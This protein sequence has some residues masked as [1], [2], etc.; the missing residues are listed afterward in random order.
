MRSMRRLAIPVLAAL[1]MLASGAGSATAAMPRIIGGQPAN[2]ESW[3]FA[4]ALTTDYGSQFCAGSLVQPQW[5]LT[6]GHC[7]IYAPSAVRVVVGQVDLRERSGGI[8]VERMIRS[9]D[10]RMSVPGAPR[11]DMMLIRLRE[12][13]AAPLIALAGERPRDGAILRVAG[14]GSTSYDAV[15]D[16]FGPSSPVLRT[17][18]VRVRAA[19]TCVRDYGAGVFFPSDMICAS[20]PGQDACAG[21]SGGPL[22]QGTGAALRLVGVVS[23]GTG[24]ALPGYPGVYS[25]VSSQRCW[26]T[27]TTTAPGPVAQLVAAPSDGALDLEWSWARPCADAPDPDGFRLRV[28]ETGQVVDVAGA[29]RDARIGGLV[30][31]QAYTMTVSAVNGNGESPGVGVSAT[32]GPAPV[33]VAGA[34]WTAPG[35]AVL[36]VDVPPQVDVLRWRGVS[37][38]T[39]RTVV[40]PWEVLVPDPSARRL[41]IPFTDLPAAPVRLRLEVE[42]GGLPVST[43]GAFLEQPVRP[44]LI[45]KVRIVGQSTVG[46]RLVCQIGRWTGTRPLAVGRS[47]LRAGRVLRGAVDRGY[48]VANADAGQ[49]LRCRVTVEGPGG[50]TRATS[51]VVTVAD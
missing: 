44:A 31:G 24:C 9:P 38:R 50:T 21:D 8:A 48:V 51:A 10:Y 18:N 13:A 4:V 49:D 12:P 15:D 20:L 11:N 39:T 28:A 22:V 35:S 36:V 23:W 25:L 14:W 17:T 47:W 41:R 26:I 42:Q 37:A 5:V 32:A 43:R 16:A 33:T 46:R 2:A 40:G 1:A 27:T 7:R 30:N 29:Q 19:E 45:G 6:A 3:P 34:S